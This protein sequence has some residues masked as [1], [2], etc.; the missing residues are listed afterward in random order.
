MEPLVKIAKSAVNMI[1]EKGIGGFFKEIKQEGFLRC[2]PDG[3]LLVWANQKL[4]FYM[5]KDP[6]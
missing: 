5:G 3:N 2:L 1:R 6:D 4:V